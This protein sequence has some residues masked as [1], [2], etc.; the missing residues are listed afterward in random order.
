MQARRVVPVV[1]IVLE[2]QVAASGDDLIGDGAVPDSIVALQRRP[3]R[4]APTVAPNL[5]M[6]T[7]EFY[8]VTR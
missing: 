1:V 2:W 3:H 7:P 5:S 4:S 8:W 6:P